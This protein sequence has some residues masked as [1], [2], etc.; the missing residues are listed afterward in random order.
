MAEKS[1]PVS[2][3]MPVY[4]AGVYLKPALESLLEQTLKEIE[5]IAVDDGSTDG[6]GQLLAE[7]AARNKR[8][9]VISLKR[10]GAAAARNRGIEAARGKWLWFADADDIAAPDLAEKM[11]RRGEETDSD[12]VICQ[13]NFL[14]VDGKTTLMKNTLVVN[15]LPPTEPFSLPDAGTFLF[16]NSA[17]WNKLYRRDF[18]IG[19]D[20]RF[21]N[22]SSCNDVAFGVLALAE[23]A[24]ICT[25]RE[26]LYN[27]RIG[28][29]GNI[30]ASRG[31]CAANIVMAAR[32]VRD[33]LERRHFRQRII[34]RFYARIVHSFAYEYK[35]TAGCWQKHKLLKLFKAFLPKA[36]FKRQ[37]KNEAPI[38]DLLFKKTKLGNKRVVRLAG[39][40]IAYH[41]KEKAVPVRSAKSD[42]HFRG[43]NQLAFCIRS[44][45]R[46]L[47]ENVDLVVGVPRSG[48]IP[49]Y[50]IALF[51]NK[52]ACSLNEFVNGCR[53]ANGNR[54]LKEGTVRQVLVVDDSVYSGSALKKTRE[55][56]A[57]LAGKYELTYL[58]IYSHPKA[59]PKPD[60]FFETVPTPR[61]FQWNYL[62]HAVAGRACF[63]I[64]GVLCFDPSEEQNDDG[65][66]Y[67]DFLLHARPLYIPGYKIAA[68]VTSR[69]EKYRPQT[70]QWL[71]E[72]G[73]QYDKLYMLN[74][75]SK[76][77]RICLGCHADFKAETYKRL[78]DCILFVESNSRQ[79]RQIAEKSGK[80]VICA[81]TDEM[82][83]NFGEVS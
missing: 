7:Y 77:E 27:Y 30:S 20:I 6:S 26:A 60:I 3:I 65:P 16:T 64:D 68:L 52:P 34:D 24:R 39:I 61:L 51:L 50:M 81:E 82:F 79:A 11:Y 56:L 43:F 23:A 54:P 13:A 70:E 62:N 32:Y 80:P 36:L 40:K 74:V 22:L 45:L 28:I 38:K 46:K 19:K 69:L 44:N 17:V 72:N 63:D 33:E 21:Q 10:N 49:A 47:P 2:V 14:D 15:R 5:I 41:K 48:I 67:V 57:P 53:P 12:M 76:E 37:F 75:A 55:I 59:D 66:K 83:G 71:R 8:L 31:R 58:C 9:K 73:V 35:Q 18:V 4:N 1:I 25:V 42:L 29:S 78:D